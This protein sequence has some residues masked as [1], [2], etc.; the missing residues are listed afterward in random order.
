MSWV[1]LLVFVLSPGGP[2]GM[3]WG[4]LG[5]DGPVDGES[6][7][8]PLILGLDRDGDERI[9]RDEFH[10]FE[11]L[12]RDGDFFLD[13]AEA[14]AE[15]RVSLREPARGGSQ[16]GEQIRPL[17]AHDRDGDMRVS[18]SEFPGSRR[19]FDRLDKDGDGFLDLGGGAPGSA[20]RGKRLGTRDR[21]RR[22]GME[23]LLEFVPSSDEPVDD[24]PESQ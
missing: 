13:T 10:I 7:L 22:W 23:D 20:L 21:S 8:P 12:D 18:P 6:G 15:N 16:G 14:R 2:A 9:S 24:K 4:F 3:E 11:R 5:G 1:A 17:P 19:L